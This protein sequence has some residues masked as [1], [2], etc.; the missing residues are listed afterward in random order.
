M[1]VRVIVAVLVALF[2]VLAMRNAKIIPTG[3]QNVAESALDFV[4]INISEEILGKEQGRRFLPIIATIFFATLFLNLTSII[5]GINISSNARIGFPLIMALAAYLTYWWV[6]V[7]KYG[8]FGFIKSSTV[9]P[10]VPLPIHFLLVPIEFLQIAIL[11]PFTLTVRLLANMLAGHIMLALFFAATQFFIV[12]KANV[13]WGGAGLVTLVVAVGFTLFELMIIFLQ[14]YI[15][16]LLTAVY[17]DSSLH[18]DSH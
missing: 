7:S 16:S 3:V 17:I 14:A 15:F 1:L 18:A 11:R 8:F 12:T 4:R 5:P 13:I 10:G 9:L 6:G 2:F